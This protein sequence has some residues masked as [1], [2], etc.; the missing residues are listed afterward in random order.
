MSLL[1]SGRLL[2]AVILSLGVF[3]AVTAAQPPRPGGARPPLD[4][5]AE[6]TARQKIAD[7]KAE[8]DVVTAVAD[9]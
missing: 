5:L 4:P 2:A 1:R 9:G 8:T 6:A 3:A 7:L